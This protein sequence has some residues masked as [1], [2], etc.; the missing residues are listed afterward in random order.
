MEA[1]S[2]AETAEE[3]NI[4]E[5][6]VKRL[7]KNGTLELVDV[8][9]ELPGIS[10][11]SIAEFKCEPLDEGVEKPK[12]KGGR[13]PKTISFEDA[14]EQINKCISEEG[15]VD[16]DSIA[17][18]IFEDVLE[19]WYI[20]DMVFV[21]QRS[22]NQFIENLLQEQEEEQ[23]AVESV[24]SYASRPV[25][26]EEKEKELQ[27]S[28]TDT[29]VGTTNDPL[30]YYTDFTGMDKQDKA[31]TQN[32]EI[33]LCETKDDVDPLIFM[34]G[35]SIDLHEDEE[36]LAAKAAE[37]AEAAQRAEKVEVPVKDNDCI[38]MNRNDFHAALNVASMRAEL[39]V[40]R[41]MK[42]FKRR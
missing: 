16:K 2:I 8:E 37:K 10:V 9:G 15:H 32:K 23:I 25:V 40:Y 3:L 1:I 20:N 19:D 27:D 4:Q 41:S 28:A 39:G 13:P 6:E 14:V 29:D 11:R 34:T 17:D 35:D 30:V 33:E 31:I 42:S 24:C 21:T 22:V 38:T 18:M 5:D 7:C 12:R 36:Y 26:T